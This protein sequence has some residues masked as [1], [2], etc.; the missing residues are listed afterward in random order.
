MAFENPR[1]WMQTTLAS[2]LLHLVVC[3]SA[4]A[5]SG[6]PPQGSADF[7]QNDATPQCQTL[8]MCLDPRICDLS[9]ASLPTTW[10]R[11]TPRPTAVRAT[12]E[13]G[14]TAITFT[15]S[16]SDVVTYFYF[17]GTLVA[18]VDTEA[19]GSDGV[20]CIPGGGV[21]QPPS[22]SSGTDLCA[23]TADAG[24]DAQD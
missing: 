6:L 5:C 19:D 18:G 14:Y 11:S 15:P 13:G 9:T 1:T 7:V 23:D 21:F 3:A 20:A 8:V 4:V 22:C 24:G 17:G 2:V 12:C 10:C 16:G